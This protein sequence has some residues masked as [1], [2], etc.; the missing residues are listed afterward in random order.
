[1][2][3]LTPDQMDSIAAGRRDT[4]ITDQGQGNLNNDN[5]QNNNGTVIE[6]TSGPPGQIQNE[7]FGCNNCETTT[8]GPGNK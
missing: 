6:S 7:K 4:S 3:A 1:L 2:V 8:S 5:V